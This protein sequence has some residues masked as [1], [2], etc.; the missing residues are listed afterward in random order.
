MI[1]RGASGIIR[2]MAVGELLR[3]A[4]QEARRAVQEDLGLA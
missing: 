3:A 4:A 2:S 1:H